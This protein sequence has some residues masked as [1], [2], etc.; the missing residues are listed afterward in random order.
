MTVTP[1]PAKTVANML[2]I[3]SYQTMIII[4]VLPPIV[5]KVLD[6]FSVLKE[7][8]S[9]LNMSAFC[10]GSFSPESLSRTFKTIFGSELCPRLVYTLME[11]LY[12]IRRGILL[13]LPS[14]THI[15]LTHNGFSVWFSK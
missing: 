15:L 4:K 6:K 10:T 8:M 14:V 1:I 7:W 2:S 9:T 3:L 13:I 5:F 11:V 12:C